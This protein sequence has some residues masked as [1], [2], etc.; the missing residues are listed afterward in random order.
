MS[1]EQKLHLAWGSLN[2]MF[3]YIHACL[4]LLHLVD[5]FLTK[6]NEILPR[7]RR[8]KITIFG[9]LFL[10]FIFYKMHFVGKKQQPT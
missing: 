9:F 3:R 10:F 2:N 1:D 4:K 6:L 7:L 8:S 5:I